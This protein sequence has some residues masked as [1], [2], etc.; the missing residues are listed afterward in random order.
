MPLTP[1]K[2]KKTIATNIKKLVE[3]GYP[4]SQ[5]VAIALSHSKKSNSR[6]SKKKRRIGRTKAV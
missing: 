3:E 1:G 4:R 5:A 2:S 6:T